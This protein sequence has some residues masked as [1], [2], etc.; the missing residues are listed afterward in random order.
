MPNHMS[1]A[2]ST[3]ALIAVLTAILAASGLAVPEH[4][5]PHGA[6]GLKRLDAIANS[7]TFIPLAALYAFSVA[8]L[9]IMPLKAASFIL[10]NATD[11]LFWTVIVLLATI[12]GCLVARFAFG[13]SGA[14]WAITDWKF[15]FAAAIIA[16]HFI[17][18]EL[19]RN[20]LLRSIGLVAAIGAT[21]ACLFWSFQL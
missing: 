4:G 2:I 15:I 21:V 12:A 1:R 3:F 16:C 11:M 20:V 17:L 18:N 8:L 14:L 10:I 13:Q 9:M 19:R 5:Y 7:A 6:I